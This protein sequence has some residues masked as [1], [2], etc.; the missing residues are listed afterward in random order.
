MDWLGNAGGLLGSKDSTEPERV[1]SGQF[2]AP[3]RISSGHRAATGL[4]RQD[5]WASA[6]NVAPHV[7][8]HDYAA[9]IHALMASSG[10]NP[11]IE[12]V[13]MGG[14]VSNLRMQTHQPSSGT[15]RCM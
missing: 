12:E 15:S 7:V 6:P 1:G 14:Q 4:V 9:G 8:H 10:Q 2:A 3:Q 5:S 11:V 13:P